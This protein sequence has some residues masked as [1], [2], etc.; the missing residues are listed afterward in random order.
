MND[1]AQSLFSGH[2][3]RVQSF[4][5]TALEAEN[6]PAALLHSGSPIYSFLDD[7]EYAF[8]PN[9]HFLHWLPLT[10]H[11]DS[12]LLI[13][14]GQR[15]RLFYFQPDDYWYLPPADPEDWWA[16]HF[17]IEV[18]RTPDGWRPALD[19]QLA[20]ASVRVEH[21]AAIGDAPALRAHFSAPGLNPAGLLD[22][23]HVRRTRKTPYELACIA[24]AARRA[25]RAHVAAEQAFRDGKSEFTIHLAYLA[26]CG[27]SDTELPYNNIVALNEH[28]AVLH[29]QARDHIVPDR[30]HSFLIDAGCTVNGYASD[31]T[32]TYAHAS[33]QFAELVKAMDSVQQGLTGSVRAGVDYKAL[34]L[35]AHR[36]IAGVLE[37]FGIIRVSADAAVESGLSSVFFPHGL[38]HFLGLQTHDVAGLIDNDG[39][40]IP[41]PEGHSA[42]RLT[43]VLEAD[44][45]LTIEPGL[46]FI[47]VLLDRWRRERDTSMIDWDRVAALAPCGGIRIE[48]NV[49]V[50]EGGCDNLTRRAF[51]E[52]T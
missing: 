34:H 44:N 14:P 45:V 33:G 10:R 42:L 38:G 3:G 12:A 16:R 25:A 49:V 52:L 51:A 17:D 32:R 36:M 15:P 18:V 7:Y 19:A 6:L 39:T 50:T 29:Y 35:Q 13:I 11:P 31:I 5:E 9:P 27:Q 8:R 1:V 46:Y 41:R 22:R 28:A 23:L 40:P 2:V 24:E 20:S 37:A 47:D 26:E 43:R 48:D 21:M 4:W 30:L